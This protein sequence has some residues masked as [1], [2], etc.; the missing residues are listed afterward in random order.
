MNPAHQMI[1]S[2]EL[3]RFAPLDKLSDADARELLR[4]SLTIQLSAGTPVFGREDR[5]RQVFYLLQGT[6]ELHGNGRPRTIAAGTPEALQP[7]G[8][9]LPGQLSATAIEA[10]TLISFDADMLELFLNWTNPNAYVVNEVGADNDHQWMNQLLQSRGLLRFSES[11]ISTLLE[12]MNE[13][14]FKAGQQVVSQDGDDDFYYVIKEGRAVVSRRPDTDSKPVKL[15][16]LSAGDAFGEESLLTATARGATVTMAQDGTLMRLSKRD[17]SELLAE[18]LL[19]TINWDEAQA[20]AATGGQFIDIRLE[21]EFDTLSIPGSINIPLPMLR[22][23]LKTLKQNRKYIIYCDDGSRSAV[24]AFLLN[25]HGYDAFIL[26]GGLASAR[27]HLTQTA[28]AVASAEDAGAA[29]QRTAQGNAYCSLADYWGASVDDDPL[30]DD[31]EAVHQVEKTRLT[32]TRQTPPSG[33]AS[34][35]ASHQTPAAKASSAAAPR[36]A[37]MAA[38]PRR[39]GRLLRN[40][41]IGVTI[42]VAGG[43][44][45]TQ[46][47]L[48]NLPTEQASV[49]PATAPSPAPRTAPASVAASAPPAVTAEPPAALVAPDPASTTFNDNAPA[50]MLIESDL[51]LSA[52]GELLQLQPTIVTPVAAPPAQPTAAPPVDPATRGFRD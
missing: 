30:F 51:Y 2:A 24:A 37:P 21:G 33:R 12:R 25:R 4:T 31:S 3:R 15:A 5:D 16:E 41:L 34:I 46:P 22:L 39:A 29:I 8:R 52:D 23:K 42:L 27:S 45:T 48:L 17:F 13:I 7:M 43:L 20:M 1:S 9:H 50:E 36:E 11:Q 38:R 19:S 35:N 6:V 14:H 44:I 28:P 18:P 32:P 10:A 26:D 40:G 49:P 47:A